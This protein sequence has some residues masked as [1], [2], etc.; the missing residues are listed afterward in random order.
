M[1][2]PDTARCVA[3]GPRR[4]GFWSGPGPVALTGLY[5]VALLGYGQFA[6]DG[7]YDHD[8]YFH[9]RYAQMLPQ[10]GLSREFAWT[11]ASTWKERFCD[12]EFLYHL[13]MAP[14][15]RD[16][17]EPVRGVRWFSLLLSLGVCAAMYGLLRAQKAPCPWLFAAA[18]TFVSAS[19]LARLEMTRSHVLSILLLL[20]GVHFMLGRRWKA[21]A[22]LG[23]VYSWS[24]TAPVILVAVAL[25]FAGGRWVA[26]GEVEWRTP[27]AAAAGVLLGLIAHPYSPLTFETFLTYSDVLRLAAAGKG[28]ADLE[29]ASELYPLSTRDF[30]LAYPLLHVALAGLCVGGWVAGRKLSPEATGALGAGIF[31]Y[32]LMMVYQRMS[33]YAAP[34]MIVAVALVLRDALAG[35]DLGRDVL[36]ARRGLG[37]ALIAFTGMVL[38]AGLSAAL[39]G[40]LQIVG[41][42]EPPRFRG[43]AEW[44]ARNLEPGQTVVNLWWDDFSDLLY[45]GYRQHYLCGLD[46]T[47]M[48]RWDREKAVK[49]ER[50]RAGKEPLDRAWLARTFDARYMV[51]T[52][53]AV[54]L[55]PALA[56]GDWRPVYQDRTAAVYALR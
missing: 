53:R 47:Y 1:S 22:V 29:M 34:L 45:D 40:Q 52:Q 56:S 17:R 54:K 8:G 9:A 27:A 19:F 51:L 18:I 41:Q 3:P 44:M 26:G 6:S 14:F 30:L 37:L 33:E 48:L 42:A 4:A 43:A 20:L 32:L 46:G 23:F 55:Y 24:Y 39:R 31:G 35:V 28:A 15:A 12:K 16:A 7:L 25:V 2:D 36:R 10:R 21:L 50:M 13:L 38:A 5:L 49:L 11:Q